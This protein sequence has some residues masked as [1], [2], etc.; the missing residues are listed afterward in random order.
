[1]PACAYVLSPWTDLTNSGETVQTLVDLDPMIKPHLLGSSAEMY[2]GDT[3]LEDPGVSPLFADLT[4]LP[5]LLIQTG[6][7]EVLLADSTRLAERAAAAGV[8]VQ[9]DLAESMWHV[10]PMFAGFMPEA[11][12]A[13]AHAARFIRAH[14]RATAAP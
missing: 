5:P 14:T 12:D 2:A 13:L 10:Y 8:Q 4:G 9:L 3:A 11:N 1:M 6:T 7:D